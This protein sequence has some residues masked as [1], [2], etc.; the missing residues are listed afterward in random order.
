MLAAVRDLRHVGARLERVEQQV[1]DAVG[2]IRTLLKM[3]AEQAARE[4]RQQ[5]RLVLLEAQVQELHVRLAAIEDAPTL[6][7]QIDA[8]TAIDERVRG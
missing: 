1:G 7:D 3:L 8:G 5:R 4:A 2:V 6:T